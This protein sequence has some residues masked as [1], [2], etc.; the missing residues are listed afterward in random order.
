ML[1]H[2]VIQCAL[3][4]P[5]RRHQLRVDLIQVLLCVLSQSLY[6]KGHQ[7]STQVLSDLTIGVAL[8]EKIVFSLLC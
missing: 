2:H 8:H 3:P 6:Q 7:S 4:S 5:Y 1:L